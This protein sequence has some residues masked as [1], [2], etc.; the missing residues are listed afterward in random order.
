MKGL[1]EI[2]KDYPL[3]SVDEFMTS[4][5]NIASSARA[6]EGKRH[7]R[8][9]E[10][11]YQTAKSKKELIKRIKA[12]CKVNKLEWELEHNSIIVTVNSIGHYYFFTD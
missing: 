2:L 3:I 1:K 7:I 5:K 9:L 4:L 10:E 12:Y 11:I 8:V 6:K